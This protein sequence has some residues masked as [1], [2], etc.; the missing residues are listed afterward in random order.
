MSCSTKVRNIGLDILRLIA[1]LLVLGRHLH[2]PPEPGWFLY[3]WQT[4]GWVGVDIFFVLSGFL[5]SGLLFCEYKD[6]GTV[7]LKR[8]LIRR[9]LKIYPAFYALIAVTLAGLMLRDNS[10]SIKALLGEIFFIQNYLGGLWN[11][12]WSLAV[13]EHFYLGIAILFALLIPQKKAVLDPFS[14]IPLIFLIVALFCLSAR[15]ANLTLYE[16]YSHRWFLFGTHIRIDSLMFGVLLS[17]LWHFKNLNTLVVKLRGGIL[18]SIAI[19]LLLPAFIFPLEQYKAISI[20][21]VILFYLGSGA[22]LLF[23]IRFSS[24]SN[25]FWLLCG[26]LGAS[27]YSIYLWHMPVSTWGWWIVKR[28]TGVESFA[29]Y[30]AFTIL[31]S[32]AVGVI[33]NKVLEWPVLKL[34]NQYFPA[35]INTDS[36]R[37]TQTTAANLDMIFKVKE[38]GKN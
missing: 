3:T 4:G 26:S 34:R 27:S 16:E 1:V 21:G 13:E 32:L 23:A 22:L 18:C 20:V 28:L 25:R 8:F 38:N 12:T 5:V 19:L 29:S 36:I 35:A 10:I 7:D 9:G 11:H 6:N 2:L 37:P 15:I 24:S 30:F 14:K 17:Y 33:M 31:G